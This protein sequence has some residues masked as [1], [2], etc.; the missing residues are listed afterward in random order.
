MDKK[1]YYDSINIWDEKEKN[2]GYRII[3]DI[4]DTAGRTKKISFVKLARKVL[5]EIPITTLK[6]ESL[7]MFYYNNG[8][9]YNNPHPLISEIAKRHTGQELTRHEFGEL[10]FQLKT[11]TYTDP[12]VFDANPY[13]VT[14]ANGVYNIITGEF[15]EHSPEDYSLTQIPVKYDY[16]ADCPNIKQFLSEILDKEDIPTI[17]KM[18][19]YCL[20]KHYKFQKVFMFIGEGANG[21]S[22]LLELIK[23]LLGGDNISNLA[24]QDFDKNRFSRII[25][26]GKLANIHNDLPNKAMYV[27]SY[28]K[29]LTGGDTISAERKFGGHT[30]FVNHAKMIYAMNRAPR[31]TEDTPAVWRRICIINFPNQFLGDKADKNILIKLIT[32]EELSGLLNWAIDGYKLLEEEGLEENIEETRKQYR[33]ISDSVGSFVDDMVEIDPEGFV[34][35]NDFYQKYV[36]W[37]KKNKAVIKAKNIVGRELPEHIPSVRPIKPTI[38][39]QRTPSYSGIKLKEDDTQSVLDVQD[40]NDNTISNTFRFH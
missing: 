23:G 35:K 40:G 2:R 32:P 33:L 20:V 34:T 31:F 21:K 26:K 25:L 8:C 16:N 37:C 5:N 36:E 9:W 7:Q 28:F 29:M 17:Q 24:L 38:G 27:L 1:D 19:G 13:S 15:K 11:M 22:T 12:K 14:C 39:K 6:D 4:F 3:E 30:N 10:E 18:M